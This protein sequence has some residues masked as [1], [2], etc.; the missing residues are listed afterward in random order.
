MIP[1]AGYNPY[2]LSDFNNYN[3]QAY[4]NSGYGNYNNFNNISPFSAWV[5][6]NITGLGTP[7]PG[8]TAGAYGERMQTLSDRFSKY[9]AYSAAFTGASYLGSMAFMFPD[10]VHAAATGISAAIGGAPLGHGGLLNR[11]LGGV[12]SANPIGRLNDAFNL[13]INAASQ[14]F[15]QPGATKIGAGLMRGLDTFGGMGSS[16]S[17]NLDSIIG[18]INEKGWLGG[19]KTGINA[20]GSKSAFLARAFEL[21]FKVATGFAAYAAVAGV[22]DTFLQGALNAAVGVDTEQD[23]I[24]DTFESLSSRV[25]YGGSGHNAKSFAKEMAKEIRQRSFYDMEPQGIMGHIGAAFGAGDTVAGRFF[26]GWSAISEMQTKT[27]QYGLMAESGLLSKSGS[28]DEFIKKAD[29]MYAAIAKLGDALGQTTTKAMETARVLKSQGISDP[30]GITNAGSAIATSA[31]MS[32][33]SHNQVMAIA[34]EATEAFRGSLFS[35]D[36]AYGLANSVIRKTALAPNLIGSQAYDKLLYEN[37]GQDSMNVNL[38]RTMAGVSNSHEMRQMLIA[39]MY[40][41]TKTGFEFTGSVNASEINNAVSGNSFLNDENTLALLNSNFQGLTQSEMRAAERSLSKFS[42]NLTGADMQNAFGAFAKRRGYGNQQ[43]MFET[44]FRQQGM[45]PD[46]AFNMAKIITADTRAQEFTYDYFNRRETQLSKYVSDRIDAESETGLSKLTFGY[47]KMFGRRT[48][49]VETG[50]LMALGAGIGSFAG[51]VGTVIGAGVGALLGGYSGSSYYGGVGERLG[52]RGAG[53]GLAAESAMHIGNFAIQAGTYQIGRSI[54][55]MGRIT[56]AMPVAYGMA[57][58]YAAD[59][60]TA[61]YL[62]DQSRGVQYGASG[63]LGAGLAAGAA[64]FGGFMIPSLGVGP[65]GLAA[66]AI[67]GTTTGLYTAYNRFVGDDMASGER[68][69]LRNQMQILQGGERLRALN[70]EAYARMVG[71]VDQTAL[72]LKMTNY[73]ASVKAMTDDVKLDLSERAGQITRAYYRG[74]FRGGTG[75]HG[76]DDAAFWDA[77]KEHISG[78]QAWFARTMD[79]NRAIK[80]RN[81]SA[82]LIF[83]DTK[84]ATLPS[85]L[86]E[87]YSGKSIKIGSTQ[88]KD[89]AKMRYML[90]LMPS[91]VRNKYQQQI[92]DSLGDVKFINESGGTAYDGKGY[93]TNQDK[94]PFERST[95]FLN[96]ELGKANKEFNALTGTKVNLITAGNAMA[97]YNLLH[98]EYGSD[99]YRKA[100]S[101]AAKLGMSQD[102]LL[103]FHHMLDPKGGAKDPAAIERMRGHIADAQMYAQD[104]V[105]KDAL[106]RFARTKSGILGEALNPVTAQLRRLLG[107]GDL[108]ASEQEAYSKLRQGGFESIQD[109]ATREFMQQSAGAFDVL[110]QAAGKTKEEYE[111]SVRGADLNEYTKRMLLEQVSGKGK[112]TTL[113]S[114]DA[115]DIRKAFGQQFAAA[116]LGAMSESTMQSLAEQQAMSLGSIDKGIQALIDITVLGD[117]KR[118]EYLASLGNNRGGLP[119]PAPNETSDVELPPSGNSAKRE[120]EW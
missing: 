40:K 69:K 106:D 18:G 41:R 74:A 52:G 103:K 110:N 89:L 4:D 85:Y 93:M 20:A 43:D 82:W 68:E 61:N 96:D 55:G 46:A 65:W 44:I 59:W 84:D 109:D 115:A 27:A 97:V 63:A 11:A 47:H 95:E 99:A 13:P 3:A 37:R 29:A 17:A 79:D 28:A 112:G 6:N 88:E 60:V 114:Q 111:A 34:S 50:G 24:S 33:Y 53:F 90:E 9:G 120:H 75:L 77:G 39:S 91:E 70:P 92:I 10:V 105:Y 108:S 87:V 104:V 22:T 1:N 2:Y 42:S 72:G 12:L 35:S 98:S 26:G 118:E 116:N 32:G 14:V 83:S 102:T 49:L 107:R 101:D 51:P 66:A 119:A 23:K 113:L 67:A 31:A 45:S 7:P 100:Q 21:P 73:N 16:L 64:A 54:L 81:R 30:L 71:S 19:I 5:Q 8:M 62:S 48:A 36:A 56:A 25:L 76:E 57:G 80:E 94:S 86:K 58:G 117:K 15:L 78:Y 38:T